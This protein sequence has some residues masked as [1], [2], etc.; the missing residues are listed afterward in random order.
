MYS[1]LSLIILIIAFVGAINELPNKSRK[2]NRLKY[3][4][5]GCFMVFNCHITISLLTYLL[6]RFNSAIPYLDI[7]NDHRNLISFLMLF[8]TSFLIKT[9]KQELHLINFII[10]GTLYTIT[11][12]LLVS[13]RFQPYDEGM[14]TISLLLNITV[15]LIGGSIGHITINIYKKRNTNNSL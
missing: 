10:L 4:L 9:L 11:W 14:L 2:E 8:F 5:L 6:Y 3:S 7:I 1:F 13:S 15:C 12:N